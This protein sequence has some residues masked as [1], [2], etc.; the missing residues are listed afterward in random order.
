MRKY[1]AIPVPSMDFIAFLQSEMGV[2]HYMC[3]QDLDQA[4]PEWAEAR[5]GR[6]TASVAHAIMHMK[7][8][9]MGLIHQLVGGGDAFKT[10]ATDH[11][12]KYEPVARAVYWSREKAIHQNMEVAQCG[13][14]V[15]PTAPCLGASPDGIVSCSCHG[16]RV[17]EIKC[18]YKHK[19]VSPD[20][21]PH[22]DPKYHLLTHTT[23][24]S[25]CVQLKRDDSWYCQAQF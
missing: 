22:I 10:P 24:N 18:T 13:L 9:S 11:G 20:D 6:I 12:K 23:D 19:D 7:P 1:Q 17:L 25:T 3:L 2:D 5:L 4:S 21:I 14:F 15:D 16:K 8:D